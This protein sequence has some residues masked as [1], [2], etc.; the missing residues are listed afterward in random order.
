MKKKLLLLF[1][2]AC[3]TVCVIPFAGMIFKPTT[4]PIGNEMKT[5]LPSVRTEDNKFN[6]DYLSELGEYFSKHFAL[7]PQIITADAKI[8]SDIFM[9]S[10][11]PSVICGKNGWLFYSSTADD[12]TGANPLSENEIKGVLNNLKIIQ[13]YSQSKG[14]RFLFTIAPN[15]NTM[16]GDNMPFY[17]RQTGKIHNRD[18]VSAAL[19]NSDINYCNLFDLF[20]GQNETLYFACDSHWNNKGALAAYNYIA[21]TL[22]KT[23]DNFESVQVVRK[24][25][26]KGDLLKMI[27]PSSDDTEYNYYY[28]AEEKYTYDT[29]TKSVEES[30]IRAH[31]DS[32]TG[33]LYM[34]RDSFGNALLPFFAGAYGNSAFT[35]SFP[36]ILDNDFENYA[37]DTFI[38]ELAERNI[39]WLIER[40]P[41]LLSPELVIHKTDRELN[42]RINA[43]IYE[44]E[45]S[46]DYLAVSGVL[47]DK[48]LNAD[49]VYVTLKCKD[50]SETTRECY[51]VFNG[52]ER[53]FLAYFNSAQTDTS[54]EIGISVII[55]DGDERILLGAATINVGGKE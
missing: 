52:Q 28:G 13:D 23:H 33:S 50:G 20:E 15:K 18:T 34:Y 46:P 2:A 21:D 48:Y 40:P 14:A 54:E 24:K 25:D 16:Y 51:T 22:G 43:K 17:Y 19:E 8:Q 9:T 31:S 7:R 30:L 41:V 4:E 32:A 42:E 39:D 1:T 11:I 5:G 3:F 36:M 55:K 45:Y 26:F 38:M 37:P 27:F 6:T 49:S 12:Y 29:D 44:C 47:D 35:K 53:Q 10:N